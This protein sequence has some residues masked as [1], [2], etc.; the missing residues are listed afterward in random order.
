MPSLSTNPDVAIVDCGASTHYAPLT[1]HCIAKKTCIVP[2]AA[3]LLDQRTITAS[4][5]ATL[6]IPGIPM[7]ACKTYIFSDITDR[8]LV[9][10]AKFCDHGYSVI[11]NQ[12]KVFVLSST[13]IKLTGERAQPNGMWF[14]NLKPLTSLHPRT[15]NVT[16][17]PPPLK[18]TFNYAH[19]INN[20]K[21][22]ILF[23]YRCFSSPVKSTWKHAVRKG[24]FISWPGLTCAAIDKYLDKSLASSKGHLR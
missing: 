22:H 3:S 4:H 7:S 11:F 15:S 17:A 13:E 14:I 18:N 1:I 24:F 6:D 12:R 8:A 19:N 16:I 20:I 21:N 5:T 2:Y 9:S 10:V 23:Y